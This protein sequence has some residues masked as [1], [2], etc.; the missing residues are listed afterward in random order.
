MSARAS[1][2]ASI[3]SPV[4]ATDVMSTCSPDAQCRSPTTPILPSPRS[5]SASRRVT[6]NTVPVTICPLSNPPMFG[7]PR[8]TASSGRPSPASGSTSPPGAALAAGAFGA[9][10]WTGAGAVS[11]AGASPD[12]GAAAAAGCSAGAGVSSTSGAG[13]WVAGCRPRWPALGFREGPWH[14]RQAARPLPARRVLG[15]PR[16][17]G[18]V[19]QGRQAAR[20]QPARRALGFPRRA[21]P[22]WYR[23]QAARPQPARPALGFPR[24]PEPVGQRPPLAAAAC[25]GAAAS[26][27]A[28]AATGSVAGEVVSVGVSAAGSAEPIASPVGSGVSDVVIGLRPSRRGRHSGVGVPQGLVGFDHGPGGPRMY[29]APHGATDLTRAKPDS[30]DA[31]SAR[32]LHELHTSFGDLART[33]RPGGFGYGL[34][35]S[36]VGA[37]QTCNRR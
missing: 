22:V 19:W 15:L 8:T 24:R 13:V 20:P 4:F 29:S 7:G 9:G 1:T 2:A 12:S 6:V 30:P 28:L 11:T 34:D 25:S 26:S 14:G 3:V 17:A 21:G 16:R 18:P 32:F 27:E 33:C 31:T 37:K 10:A 23:W 35:V 5:T 36:S